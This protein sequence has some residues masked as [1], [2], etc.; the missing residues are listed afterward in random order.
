MV[1]PTDRPI[2][3]SHLTFLA[4]Q[5]V[6]SGVAHLVMTG[7]PGVPVEIVM[8]TDLIDGEGIYLPIE[9]IIQGT[10]EV[11]VITTVPLVTQMTRILVTQRIREKIVNLIVTAHTKERVTR[12]LTQPSLKNESGY[13]IRHR[14]LKRKC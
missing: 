2:I 13:M 9:T 5:V 4:D 10:L 14:S 8:A 12:Q 11:T 7:H 1:V 3:T 6:V